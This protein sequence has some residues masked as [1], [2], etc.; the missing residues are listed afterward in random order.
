LRQIVNWDIAN[1]CIQF[2]VGGGHAG[3]SPRGKILAMLEDLPIE[4]HQEEIK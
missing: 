2:I 4:S 1:G 3:R